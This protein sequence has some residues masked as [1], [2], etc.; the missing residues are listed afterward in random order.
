[1]PIFDLLLFSNNKKHGSEV[2]LRGSG[3]PWNLRKFNP[4][5][6][7]NEFDFKI[8]V[9]KNSD[10]YDRYLCRI[11]E[12]KESIKKIEHELPSI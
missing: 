4:Y 5:E 8:S 3:V 12:M 6:Y 7:Y 1:M 2:M 11:K 9:G 10:C